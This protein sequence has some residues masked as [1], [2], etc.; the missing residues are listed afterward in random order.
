MLKK[1]PAKKAAPRKVTPIAKTAVTKIDPASL[2]TGTYTG[3]CVKCKT[4]DTKY[5]GTVEVSKTGMNM[6]KGPCPTCGTKICRILG[7]AK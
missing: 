3:Y 2:P 1:T 5:Q 6:A 7:K 4:K